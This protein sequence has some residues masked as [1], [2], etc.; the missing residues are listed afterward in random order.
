MRNVLD[1]TMRIVESSID[2][3]R[4]GLDQEIW[5]GN[6]EGYTLQPKVLSKI[7]D[8]LAQWSDFSLTDTAEEMR[9]VGSIGTNQY[10]DDA[11]IDIHITPDV[12][13][14]PKDH[15]P[16]EWQSLIFR[17]FKDNRDVI[18]G[19]IGKHPIEVYLQLNPY[20]DL[21]SDAVYD[22]KTSRWV[23]GPGTAVAGFDPY[24]VYQHLADDV[25]D[26]SQKADLAFGELQ[27]DTIDY[28]VI[29][30][31]IE[32]A[33]DEQKQVLLSKLK[34]K[35]QEIE[36]DCEELAAMKKGWLDIRKRKSQPSSPEEALH[37]VE[38]AKEWGD[39]NAIFKFLD[40]YTYM[41]MIRDLEDMLADKVID[42]E[43]VDRIQNLMGTMQGR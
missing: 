8:T 36:D 38:R 4:D 27:R 14:L 41:K 1:R 31:A 7:K 2:Y 34:D 13:R 43:E 18:D 22:I 23:K 37:D 3:P 40:R 39:Q 21:M 35:L 42:D 6:E 33:P 19:Y 17:Y 10:S 20:Q 28:E 24:E 11:D 9:L 15:T 12:S 29:K 5:Q 16:E 25:R 32:E 30:K 26:Y